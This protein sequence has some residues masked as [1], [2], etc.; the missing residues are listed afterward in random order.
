MLKNLKKNTLKLTYLSSVIK[1]KPRQ[2]DV[3]KEFCHTE[4]TIH[5]PVGK[6]LCVVLFICTFN[7]FDSRNKMFMNL[8]FIYL[9]DKRSPMT[10]VF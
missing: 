3:S 7:C 9:L 2:K 6:P 1:W 4:H 5:N 8:L 10:K